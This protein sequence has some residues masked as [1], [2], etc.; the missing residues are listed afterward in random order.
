MVAQLILPKPEMYSAGNDTRTRQEKMISKNVLRKQLLTIQNWKAKARKGGGVE[1]PLHDLLKL[2]T[3]YLT[4]LK[5][6]NNFLWPSLKRNGIIEAIDKNIEVQLNDH[7]YYKGKKSKQDKL[8]DLIKALQK[9][10][11]KGRSIIG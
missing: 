11:K 5:E 2:K 10:A 3:T 1:K 9:E 4:K 7:V 8:E 6:V